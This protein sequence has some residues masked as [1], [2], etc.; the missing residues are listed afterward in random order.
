MKREGRKRLG[1]YFVSDSQHYS[2]NA[3]LNMR[4]RIQKK[5]EPRF[6]RSSAKTWARWIDILML[7]GHGFR[8]LLFAVL[9][10]LKVLDMCPEAV[11]LERWQVGILSIGLVGF[12]RIGML[13][14]WRYLRKLQTICNRGLD[15]LRLLE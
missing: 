8:V 7:D 4:Y 6:G 2:I 9:M 1:I 14:F 10:G 11:Q 15:E 3:V 5:L 13:R 12:R